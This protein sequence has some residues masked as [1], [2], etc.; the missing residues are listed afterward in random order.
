MKKEQ[1]TTSDEQRERLL[2]AEQI[3]RAAAEA[4]S[5]S[6]SV[7]PPPEQQELKR[8][9]GEKVV[10]AAIDAFG[11]LDIIINNAGI[12]RD[13]A[14]TNMDDSLWDP[15][16]NVH[17]RSTYKVTKAAWPIFLKQKYGR[18]LTTSSSVGI[19][20]FIYYSSL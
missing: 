16:L 1:L 2:I 12:L 5:T 8:E 9:E 3:E 10:Q 14:F 19:C 17:L 6:S 7:S 15:V 13:K 4:G 18:I 11:R 20:E